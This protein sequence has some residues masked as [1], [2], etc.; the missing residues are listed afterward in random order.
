[1]IANGAPAGSAS[2]ANRPTPGMSWAPT[3]TVPPRLAASVT[4][5]LQS[6][7]SK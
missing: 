6:A 7:T 4:V 3:I 1:M 5:A 2:I